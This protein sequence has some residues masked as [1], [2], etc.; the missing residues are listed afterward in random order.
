VTGR[1]LTAGEN[2]SEEESLQGKTRGWPIDNDPG[3]NILPGGDGWTS[4]EAISEN[5]ETGSYEGF[6]PDSQY[7]TLDPYVT[8]YH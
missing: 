1:R 8:N 7:G 5:R 2:D 4:F 6:V 3:K